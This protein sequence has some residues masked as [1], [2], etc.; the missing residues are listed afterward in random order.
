MN[1]RPLNIMIAEN[2]EDDRALVRFA[3][4]KCTLSNVISFVEDGEQL[5]DY[6]YHRGS[7]QDTVNSVRPDLILLDL[8]MPRV[9]GHEALKEIKGDPKLRSIPVVIFT[10]SKSIRDINSTYSMGAN[11]FIIKPITYDGLIQVMN[12]LAAYWSEVTELPLISL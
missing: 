8:D 7:Y 9:N 4:A 11:S 5:L 3:F 10:T 1:K 2:D 12:V 6:L